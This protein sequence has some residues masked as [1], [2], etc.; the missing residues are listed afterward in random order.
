MGEYE[1]PKTLEEGKAFVRSLITEKPIPETFFAM[2]DMLDEVTD[3]MTYSHVRY[4][5][6]AFFIIPMEMLITLAAG[7]SYIRYEKAVNLPSN[8]VAL[9][10][11]V[12]RVNPV[13]GYAW[14]ESCSSELIVTLYTGKAVRRP[15][16]VLFVSISY[17]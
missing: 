3:T 8:W 13:F 14:V 6:F 2:L 10:D 1:L 9:G 7:S 5:A 4:R 12:M 11:S 15:S 17:L 16:S